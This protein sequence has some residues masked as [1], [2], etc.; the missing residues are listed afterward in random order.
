MIAEDCP[1]RWLKFKNKCFGHPPAILLSWKEAESYC[2]NWSPGAHLASI[3]SEE[4]QTFLQQNF[5]QTV[6]LGGSDIDQEGSWIWSDGTCW[7]Y[8]NWHSDEPDNSGSIQNCLLGNLNEL[9]WGD[10]YCEEKKM[11]VCMK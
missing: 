9:K 7:N 10:A 5:P 8:T 6:W 2:Q 1:R 3:S 11:F 4:E